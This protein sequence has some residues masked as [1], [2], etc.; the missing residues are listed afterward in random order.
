MKKALLGFLLYV[1]H[2]VVI[3]DK[4]YTSQHRVL[5]SCWAV[6]VFAAVSSLVAGHVGAHVWAKTIAVEQTLIVMLGRCET[7]GKVPSIYIYINTC[8]RNIDADT[9]SLLEE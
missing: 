3:V 4:K 2:V 1:L 9:W 6:L 5:E 8:D 7:N